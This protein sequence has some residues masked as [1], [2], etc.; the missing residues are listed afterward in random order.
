MKH[1]SSNI[2]QSIFQETGNPK[3]KWNFLIFQEV[4]FRA[5]KIK[6]TLKNLFII[7]KMEAYFSKK[8]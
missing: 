6:T 8:L 5:Q 4:T 1:S 2:K 3:C 7:W